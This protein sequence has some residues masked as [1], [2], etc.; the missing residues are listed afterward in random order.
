VKLAKKNL[1]LKGILQFLGK[2]IT[3]C[4][5]GND[6][7]QMLNLVVSHCLTFLRHHRAD[8]NHLLAQICNLQ[9]AVEMKEKEVGTLKDKIL[10]AERAHN[11]KI[12]KMQMDLEERLQQQDQNSDQL[13]Y[14]YKA[15]H[16]TF[17]NK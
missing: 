5:V 12:W 17:S 15:L 13:G 16:R 6:D 2:E 9:K 1:E 8:E 4:C 11:Q 7:E 3:Y 14:L 10:D